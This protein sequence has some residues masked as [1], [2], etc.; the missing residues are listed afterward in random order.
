M[1]IRLSRMFQDGEETDKKTF[2]ARFDYKT[3][4]ILTIHRTTGQGQH[5]EMKV[6]SFRSTYHTSPEPS[7]VLYEPV[8]EY[9]SEADKFVLSG[10][11]RKPVN[12]KIK[13]YAQSWLCREGWEE[14]PQPEPED[15]GR[16]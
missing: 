3:K 9:I 11:E 10:F 6:A 15:K 7:D 14:P 5:R 4:G 13:R 2:F 8:I 16:R 12:G 1:K